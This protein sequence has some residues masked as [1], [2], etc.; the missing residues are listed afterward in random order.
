M[1]A[2]KGIDYE[3]IEIDLRN[4]PEWLYGLNAS[5]KVPVLDDGFVLP[6]SAVIMEYLEERLPQLLEA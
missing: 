5:G 4:R 1:L 3:P 6:E 2:E